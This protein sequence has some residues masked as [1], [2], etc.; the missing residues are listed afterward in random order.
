[1]KLVLLALW[2]L[3]LHTLATED[4][5]MDK[6]VKQQVEKANQLFESRFTSAEAPTIKLA[7]K[8][9]WRDKALG[10]HHENVSYN[11]VLTD[12]VR[13]VLLSAGKEYHYH[14]D[15]KDRLFFCDTEKVSTPYRSGW[16]SAEY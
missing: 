14:G 6:F 5:Y 15:D 11:Q 12:G 4:V 9:I 10:C 13:I 1:M 7:E 16:Q 3:S 8:V 2:S